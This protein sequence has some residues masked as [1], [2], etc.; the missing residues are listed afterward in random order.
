MIAQ[1]DAWKGVHSSYYVKIQTL[2]YK[3]FETGDILM[4]WGYTGNSNIY[5][6]HNRENY[7]K[8]EYG[9]DRDYTASEMTK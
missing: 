7:A 5:M 3:G 1:S 6:K 4:I 2:T 9:L 8:K